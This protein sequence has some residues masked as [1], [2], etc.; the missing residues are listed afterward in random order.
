MPTIR[1][2]HNNEATITNILIR[3]IVIA[4]LALRKIVAAMATTTDKLTHTAVKLDRTGRALDHSIRHIKS[5][6]GSQRARFYNEMATTIHRRMIVFAMLIGMVVALMAIIGWV[7]N[8][9][10]CSYRPGSNNGYYYLCTT[11]NDD[12][13]KTETAYVSKYDNTQLWTRTVNE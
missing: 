12:G 4:S 6:P 8:D 13:S 3:M 9:T 2:A 11:K 7:N 1:T 5:M 10:K